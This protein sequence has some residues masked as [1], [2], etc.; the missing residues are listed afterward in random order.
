[1]AGRCPFRPGQT[2]RTQSVALPEGLSQKVADINQPGQK[3]AQHGS[4]GGSEQGSSEKAEAPKPHVTG[5]SR[6][7]NHHDSGG[8]V[9]ECEDLGETVID[10]MDSVHEGEYVY[11]PAVAPGGTSGPSIWSEKYH[12]KKRPSLSTMDF[13]THRS[14]RMDIDSVLTRISF[15]TVLAEIKHGRDARVSHY[16]PVRYSFR[17][18]CGL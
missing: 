14:H 6:Y 12:T 9:Q 13:L 17:C 16:C 8:D 5:S 7:Q 4:G 10:S 2:A 11:L 18:R 1:M 3:P 15:M